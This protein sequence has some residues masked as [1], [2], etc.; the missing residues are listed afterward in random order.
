[1]DAIALYELTKQF[2]PVTALDRITLQ[3]P[4]Q[5]FFGCLSG[6]GGGKTTLIRLLAGLCR[7]T[8]GE[9]EVL[10]FSPFFESERCHLVSGT[11]L[12]SA[13][14]Y[15]DMTLTENLRVFAGLNGLRENE[16]SERS[17]FLL[18]ELDIWDWR[19]EK[20]DDMP[21]GVLYRGALARALIHR[22]KVLLMDEPLEGPDQETGQRIRSVLCSLRE[23][24]GLSLL[25]TTQNLLFAQ[26]LCDQ[27]GV[28]QDGRLVAK[29]DFET[30]RQGADVRYQAELRIGEAEK[31]PRGF[32]QGEDGL[33]TKEVAGQDEMARIIADTVASGIPLYEAR[34]IQPML[35][36]IYDA[37]LVGGVHR[38]GEEN[39][40]TEDGG[41]DSQPPEDGDDPSPAEP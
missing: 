39:E 2:G 34:M 6:K 35:Q 29:G 13:Q 33:W 20:V 36:E 14:L 19:D 10:G 32:T 21:T 8:S 40:R 12:D 30:L 25:L 31:G 15:A 18:H 5:T 22:P 26:D 23:E 17:S 28:L 9:C 16:I 37:V 24:E 7:P 11:V 38:G 27:F 3:V 41:D 4:E 1:M